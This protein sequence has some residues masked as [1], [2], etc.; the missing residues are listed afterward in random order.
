MNRFLT[1]RATLVALLLAVLPLHVVSQDDVER[2]RIHG[3]NTVGER[4]MPAL[5]ESWLS[6]I[7]YKDIKRVARDPAR[8]EI[9]AERDDLP[10][11]V[12]IDKQGSAAG[13]TDLIDGN[14]ELAMLSRRPNAEELDAAWQLGDLG[15]PDQEYVIALDGV[16]IVVHASNPIRE[17]SVEQ[18]RDIF[19]GK[20]RNWSEI[21]G[22]AAPINLHLTGM[23][24]GAREFFQ[25]RVM[26]DMRIINTAVVQPGL[27]RV[28]KAVALDTSAIGVVGLRSMIPKNARPLAISNG[29][30]AV[31]PTRLNSMSEDYPLV[32]RY[33]LY[34]GQLMSALGRSL[35]LYALTGRG[36]HAV[37][38]AGHFAVTLRPA[39]QAP[40]LKALSEYN[41][42]IAGAQRLPVSLRFN[43]GGTLSIFDSRSAHDIDR[44][45]AFMRLP[46][47]RGKQA[48]VVAF[49]D[50]SAD[51]R[52]VSTILSNERADMV[53]GILQ[54][55]GIVVG[56][57]NGLGTQRPLASP[58][59][60][61]AR[62]L[63]ERVEVW[64]L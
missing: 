32:R 31:A 27:V 2:L 22:R 12:E 40:A 38:R 13:M 24:S 18:L 59:Q 64:L 47:N 60:P 3:S 44:L 45:T 34:G 23:R 25:V 30:I 58:K 52:I 61:D 9:H 21:G 41:S 20:I 14:S 54:Q 39:L 46:Q 48:V 57:S 63:N 49:V 33:S 16:A 43:F 29:G 36:Q 19:A 55:R 6:S 17:L 62:F 28:G 5:I 26:S 8:L 51:S 4:L 35:A 56:R 42:M 15:S 37:E 50:R 11:I 53:T 10:L 1:I 7:G